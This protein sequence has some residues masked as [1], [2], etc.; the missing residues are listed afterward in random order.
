MA[1]P[2]PRDSRFEYKRRYK[3]KD[4]KLIEEALISNYNE[5]WLTY[6]R[7]YTPRT[8]EKLVYSKDGK[9]NQRYV[10]HFDEKGNEIGFDSF[11]VFKNPKEVRLRATYTYAKF[12][13][14]GNWTQRTQSYTSVKDGRESSE[15]YETTF[16]TITYYK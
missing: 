3:Y 8:I 11:D 9:L 1:D 16:R 4:G 2:R 6:R 15:P 5:L 10:H 12:D 14:V 13:A 7:N